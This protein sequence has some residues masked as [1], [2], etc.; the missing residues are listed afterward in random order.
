MYVSSIL[1]GGA[2]ARRRARRALGVAVFAISIVLISMLAIPSTRRRIADTWW[3][4]QG[5]FVENT[6]TVIVR[7]DAVLGHAFDP[8]MLRVHAGTT[9][10]WRFQDT[11]ESGSHNVVSINSVGDRFA[12]PVL[13]T[14]VYM[15]R[16]D[17]PGLYRYDC[18]L[19][20]YMRG[21]VEV[22]N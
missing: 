13:L 8:P 14:G 12:S 18:T 10:T 7:D 21:Y 22:V 16:F 9:V 4:A 6:V 19:H 17:T 3:T 11:G 15:H 5:R 2:T 20:A 1:S